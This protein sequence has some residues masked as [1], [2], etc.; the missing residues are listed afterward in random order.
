MYNTVK[1][2]VEERDL[3]QERKEGDASE[4]RQ[5]KEREREQ[6]DKDAQMR[7]RRA[8]RRGGGGVFVWR[9]GERKEVRENKKQ[10]VSGEGQRSE[11]QK[12]SQGLRSNSQRHTEQTH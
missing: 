12:K 4:H 3:M 8:T 7:G 5:R 6:D 9:K 11:V 10:S 2:R 1:T